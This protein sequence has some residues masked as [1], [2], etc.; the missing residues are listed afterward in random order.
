LGC[1]GALSHGEVEMWHIFETSFS[2]SQSYKNPVQQ[3]ALTV[4]FTNPEGE[5]TDVDA[6]W[7]GGNIWRV[8]F[9]PDAE[10]EWS[11]ITSC[12]DVENHSLNN[13][14]GKFVCIP[15][16]DKRKL[17]SQGRMRISDDGYS[18]AY[19]DG[20]PF[21]WLACTA[22]NGA[23][24]SDEAEWERYLTDRKNKGFT[25]IQ[26]VT[27]Q[28]RAA[29]TDR[30]G[31]KAFEGKERITINPEFFQ[32]LDKKIDAINEKDFLA[33]PVMLWAYLSEEDTM[34]PGVILNDEQA[35]VLARY[36]YARYGAHHVFW[37]LGGD[38]SYYK[39]HAQRWRTIGRGVFGSIANSGKRGLATLHPHG[40]SWIL[41]YYEDEQW[42]DI[43]GYQSTHS[44][45]PS[46]SKWI[47]TGPP[48][49]GWKGKK[50]RPVINLEP[51]YEHIRDYYFKKSVNAYFV[52]RQVYWSTLVSPTAGVTYGGQ[53]IWSWARTIAPP[54]NHRG[55]ALPWEVALDYPGST[56]MGYLRKAFEMTDW[57]KL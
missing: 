42:Y 45:K 12:S 15:S 43:T 32:R 10:G 22:W 4:S 49:N 9:Q 53:G 8:R 3:V 27:T 19:N 46:G 39:E 6:F 26:F 56:Q 30:N 16:N 21:F 13:K 14:K 51:C 36:I 54:L 35:I 41:D 29:Y 38:G 20:T 47:C 33:A 48:S 50:P 7:D 28:W 31:Q 40:R 11:Y 18:L 52:R 25:A 57:W 34:S 55:T 24:H 1:S 44:G 2:S 5:T 17:F 23:L 37:M